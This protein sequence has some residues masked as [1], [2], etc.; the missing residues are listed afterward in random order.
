MVS[1]DRCDVDRLLAAGSGVAT[2]RRAIA[3]QPGSSHGI[4]PSEIIADRQALRLRRL[5]RA[6]AHRASRGRAPSC[7]EFCEARRW[8]KSRENDSEIIMTLIKHV[9]FALLLV[10]PLASCGTRSTSDVERAS[11]GGDGG[12]GGGGGEE[13]AFTQGYWKNHP[14]AWPVSSLTLGGVS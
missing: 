13:C 4:Y 11:G 12:G 10:S 6:R 2:A 7:A 1:L 5:A 3:S 8:Q 9:I 14:D